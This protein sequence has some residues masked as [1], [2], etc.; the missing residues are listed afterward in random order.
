MAPQIGGCKPQSGNESQE[1]LTPPSCTW[2]GVCQ[3]QATV[4]L[5]VQD[6]TSPR[7]MATDGFNTNMKAVSSSRDHMADWPHL[8]VAQC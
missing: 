3:Q 8:G 7:N 5:G 2:T 1:T 6:L 4:L